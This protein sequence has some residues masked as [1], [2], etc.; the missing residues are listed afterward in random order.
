M[1]KIIYIL[2]AVMMP[3]L[4]FAEDDIH[5]LFQKGNALYAKANYKEALNDYQKI[6]D[7]GYASAAVYFNMGNASYKD[8]DI[9]SALLYYEKA[10]KYAPGDEDINFNIRFVNQKT[11]D[12]I[13][14]AP[15]LF[16]AKWWRACILNFSGHALAVSSILIV[17]IASATLIVYFFAGGITLKKVSFFASIILF[18]VGGCVVFLANRQAAYFDNHRQAIIFSSSVTIKSAPLDKAG[19]LFVL[20][21]GTLVNV[22]ATSNGWIK[23][24]LAN[25]NEGWMKKEDVKEI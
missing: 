16:L 7:N 12:K 5:A 22:M 14:E 25:G 1:K 4:S 8:G 19:N 13:E 3:V 20:H 24:R 21:D 23:I 17:F 11:T 10:H 9:P 15:E 6:I 18:A 2:L